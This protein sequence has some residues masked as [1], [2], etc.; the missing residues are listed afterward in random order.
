MNAKKIATSLPAEQFRALEQIRRRLKLKRSEAVQQALSLW[1]AG[2]EED[3]QVRRYVAGY[4]RRPEDAPAARAY[5]R[6]WATG[7]ESEDW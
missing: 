3:E 5:V 2:R 1:L 7:Q 4:Q 6:A